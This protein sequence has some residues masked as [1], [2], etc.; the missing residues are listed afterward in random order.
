MKYY[1]YFDFFQPLKNVKTVLNS[2]AYKN[3]RQAGFS[4]EAVVC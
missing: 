2:I 4:L 1:S 3:R